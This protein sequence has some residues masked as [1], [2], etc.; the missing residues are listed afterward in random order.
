M[1]DADRGASH[2][3]RERADPLGCAPGGRHRPR[4]QIL[5][6]SIRLGDACGVRVGWRG[7]AM[8]MMSRL[9]VLHV[10]KFYPPA[11]GGMERMVQLL[12][13]GE[14]ATTNSRVL[15]ANTTNRTT[16]EHWQ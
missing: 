7:G 14:Q 3:A 10:G 12:C 13:E 6:A 5:V 15:V 16:R 2:R 4:L 1:V 11:P 9:S 8:Q